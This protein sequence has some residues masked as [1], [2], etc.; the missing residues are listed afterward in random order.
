MRQV[1]L[2]RQIGL[3]SGSLAPEIEEPTG[4]RIFGVGNSVCVEDWT[5]RLSLGFDVAS[6]RLFDPGYL[7][8]M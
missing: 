2:R 8:E 1:L 4:S 6:P 5:S 3:E 7:L